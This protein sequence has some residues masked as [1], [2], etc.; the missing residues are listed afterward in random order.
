MKIDNAL[1]LSQIV[2]EN[3]QAAR[4]F[5]KYGLDFCCKGKRSLS[6]ACAEKSIEPAALI[7]ELESVLNEEEAANDFNN[8]SL[9]ELAGYITRVHHTYVKLNGPQALHYVAR[10]ASKHGDRFPYMKEVYLRFAELMEDLE[11]H[12][13]KEEKVLF[14]RIRQIEAGLLS[15]KEVLAPI[16]V[17]E[18]EHDRAGELLQEIRSLTNNY[19]APEGACTTHRLALSALQAFEQ[20]LHQH[21]HLENNLLFPKAAAFKQAGS[22]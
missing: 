12:M 16:S 1:T 21:V 7:A 17:M 9:S 13:Q 4:V 20:D 2:T 18:A 11:A 10:V 15:G 22:E 3:Y 5:E 6:L 8:Y 19:N 14:P